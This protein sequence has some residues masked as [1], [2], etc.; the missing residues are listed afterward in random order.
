M[1]RWTPPLYGEPVLPLD[2]VSF[3]R[4]PENDNLW[5]TIG[6]HSFCYQYEW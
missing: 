3:S 4:E 2:V 1:Q 5:G 6:E